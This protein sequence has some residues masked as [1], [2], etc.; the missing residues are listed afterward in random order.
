MGVLPKGHS[1]FI[2]VKILTSKKSKEPEIRK[3][4]SNLRLLDKLDL[5]IILFFILISLISFMIVL[6]GRNEIISYFIG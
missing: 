6:G 4:S 3:G 5:K 1:L 2:S